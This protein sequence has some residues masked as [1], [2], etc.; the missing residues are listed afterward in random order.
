MAFSEDAKRVFKGKGELIGS[1][2]VS[3]YGLSRVVVAGHKG[4]RSVGP[5]EIVVRLREGNLRV[6]G[7][8]LRVDKASPSEIFLEGRIS[9]LVF[10]ERGEIEK[11]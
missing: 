10:P 3:V 1:S 4:L 5:E 6:T 2:E 8:G 9:A 11:G 7:D